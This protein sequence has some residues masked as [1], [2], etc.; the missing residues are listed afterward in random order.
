MRT[1][2]LCAASFRDSVRRAAGVEPVLSPPADVRLFD[3]LQV[4][5]YD[6][7]YFKL[8][9]LTGQ[10]YWYG[11]DFLA[12]VKAD[13]IRDLDLSGAVVFAA[14]CYL[15]EYDPSGRSLQP[16]GPMFQALCQTGARAVVGGGGKNFAASRK[17]T[18]ADYLG[19]AFR[20]GLKMGL[21]PATAFRAARSR[22]GLR[23][24]ARFGLTTEERVAIKDALSFRIFERGKDYD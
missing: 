24:A 6:F 22:V 16:W 11:D 1:F 13:Q 14:N 18:G 21:S 17:V 4:E 8:H 7:Y 2:A 9:G 23:L 15:Y 19:M 3:D 20:H 12:A 10:A 5:G